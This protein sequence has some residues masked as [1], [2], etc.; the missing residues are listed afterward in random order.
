M[1][2]KSECCKRYRL[3]DNVVGVP[4]E[5]GNEPVQVVVM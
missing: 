4:G 3:E 2:C 5:N 1:E